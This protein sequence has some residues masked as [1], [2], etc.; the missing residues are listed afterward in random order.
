M[1]NTCDTL[2]KQFQDIYNLLSRFSLK[3]NIT[4]D[5]NKKKTVD[6]M[7]NIKN[8]F[9][10]NIWNDYHNFYVNNVNQTLNKVLNDL[11][12][13]NYSIIQL[14]SSHIKKFTKLKLLKPSLDLSI[15]LSKQKI[16]LTNLQTVNNIL[17]KNIAI[18]KANIITITSSPDEVVNKKEIIKVSNE[19][20]ELYSNEFTKIINLHTTQ[21]N[22]LTMLIE[23][24]FTNF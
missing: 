12:K 2:I 15:D 5:K 1:E 23:Y 3:Y 18:M 6:V 24:V 4:I 10:K 8:E 21:L 16:D 19:Y 14:S 17:I 7:K 20:I 22:N 9:H 11:I 13:L